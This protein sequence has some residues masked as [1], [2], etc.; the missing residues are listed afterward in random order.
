MNKIDWDNAPEGAE[1]YAHDYFRRGLKNGFTEIYRIDDAEW[2]FGL[3][4]VDECKKA[5]D[6]QPRPAT[7][8]EESRI[9]IIATNG[10][11]GAHYAQAIKHDSDKPRYDLIPPLA[12]DEFAKVLTFGAKKYAPD[13]WKSVERDRYIA[14]A[15]RHWQALLS[16]ETLDEESKLH[17]A[18]HL[19]CCAAFIIEM[20]SE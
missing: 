18:A 10:G 3:F 17:H 5:D 9:D 4:T 16:G 1:F 12:L 20:D 15:G 13:A 14:A 19:M 6:Y 7:W 8:P 2:S 11:D